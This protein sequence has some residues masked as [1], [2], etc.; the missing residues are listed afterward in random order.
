MFDNDI[1]KIVEVD[2][3]AGLASTVEDVNPLFRTIERSF[4]TTGNRISWDGLSDVR[5]ADVFPARSGGRHASEV[6]RRLEAHRA[7]L[8]GWLESAGVAA[9]VEVVW[10]GD[11][12]SMGLRMPLGLLLDRFPALFSLPQHSYVVPIDGIWCLNYVMEGALYFGFSAD[13]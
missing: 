9:D 1:L 13:L 12:T 8:A 2:L 4:P 5:R 6:Q 3:R 7:T 10:L 11:D